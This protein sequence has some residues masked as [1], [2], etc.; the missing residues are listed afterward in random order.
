MSKKQTVA[1]NFCYLDLPIS[2]G[3]ACSVA[4]H[5]T[6]VWVACVPPP[7]KNR[8]GTLRSLFLPSGAENLP[9]YAAAEDWRADVT[10]GCWPLLTI[11]LLS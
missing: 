4:K 1:T 3:I 5:F 8:L 11:I 2:L 6:F 7:K 9:S 10:G